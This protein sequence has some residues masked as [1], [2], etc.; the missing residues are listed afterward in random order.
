LHLYAQ[1]LTARG[2]VE[3]MLCILPEHRLLISRSALDSNGAPFFCIQNALFCPIQ[4]NTRLFCAIIKEKAEHFF[5]K[6]TVEIEIRGIKYENCKQKVTKNTYKQQNKEQT[7][8]KTTVRLPFLF[9]VKLKLF[10]FFKL[11]KKCVCPNF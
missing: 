8:K 7:H 2:L 6:S 5:E 9:A 10:A 11:G 4:L 3:R 1:A